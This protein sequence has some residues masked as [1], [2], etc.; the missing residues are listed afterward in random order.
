MVAVLSLLVAG[1][2][3][4]RVNAHGTTPQQTL[5]QKLVAKFGL[6]EADIQSIFDEIQTERQKEMQTRFDEKLTQAVK[7]GKITQAQKQAILAK[8]KELQVKNQQS[9]EELEAWA[10]A[11]NIDLSYLWGWHRGFMHE[12]HMGWHMK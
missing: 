6:K 8:Y 7:D 2:L 9:R 4:A 3:A 12:H 1:A 10:R 11:N 5:I